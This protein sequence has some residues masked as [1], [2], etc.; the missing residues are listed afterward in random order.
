LV[1]VLNS[2]SISSTL[3]LLVLV[4]NGISTSTNRN[5]RRRIHDFLHF[6]CVRR[7]T[8]VVFVV[9][10]VRQA[11]NS[12]FLQFREAVPVL[13]RAVLVSRSSTGTASRRFCVPKQYRYCFA[14]FLCFEAVQVLL[15][16][17]SASRSITCTASVR[18]I[19]FGAAL[20]TTSRV[21]V[22]Y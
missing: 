7:R 13:L 6:W 20:I 22:S 12:L 19:N 2:T 14:P 10:L 4:L 16:A 1:L 21:L 15:R 8:H 11:P 3:Y 18:Y 9:F 5:I 17:I